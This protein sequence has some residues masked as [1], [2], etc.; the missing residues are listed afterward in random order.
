MKAARLLN[1]AGL[2]S[3][4]LT[5]LP[6]QA[7]TNR[8]LVDVLANDPNFSTLVTAIQTVD[9]A[10]I[11]PG[12]LI[13]T[14]K[15]PGP[16]TV[17]A[18]DNAAFAALPAGVLPSLLANPADLADVLFYHVLP[19]QVTAATVLQGG[20]AKTLLGNKVSFSTS[21]GS[22][23]VN[24]SQILTVDKFVDNGVIHSIDAVLSPSDAPN[25][26]FDILDQDAEFTL[27]TA[28]IKA[29]GLQSTLEG[30]GPFTLLAPVNGAFLNLP[31]GALRGLL[32]NPAA[33]ADV[34]KFHVIPGSFRASVVVT[35]ATA[36]TVQ[37]STIFVNPT[38][39]GLFVDEAQVIQTDVLASNG[40]VH[41]ISD[42]LDPAPT[43]V[44]EFLQ[45]NSNFSTLVTAVG[46]AG[47]GSTLS[48]SGP[49]T[50]FAPTNRAFN[51]LAPGTLAGL[52]AN[53]TQ[54]G[55][56]LK[57][58]VVPG[59][60]FAA[61][62]LQLTTAPTVL[63]PVVNFSAAGNTV[64]VNQSKIQLFDIELSNG[65]IHAID[66]VLTVPGP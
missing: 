17:F 57:Y 35:L 26:I 41:V 19:A 61:D 12:G 38:P 25:S 4:A 29:A 21:G 33:L 42:V 22:A 40:I 45:T 6:A 14:L 36:P 47:L 55:N 3:L 50:V 34:L 31:A 66:T 1:A 60:F 11:V 54:L 2:L 23:F 63:G 37:G 52:L 39:A 20:K 28:A 53:P 43:T 46:A 65:V 44:V 27:L 15:G 16:F 24:T 58:H 8:D 30:P 49:F 59:K 62:V 5:A 48:G 32:N 9:A 7:Q 13:N 51:K 64:F 56:V 18:P 10:G